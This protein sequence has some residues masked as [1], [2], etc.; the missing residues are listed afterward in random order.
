MYRGAG[1][2]ITAP[3]AW[4]MALSRILRLTYVAGQLALL[5]QLDLLFKLCHIFRAESEG[6]G[7]LLL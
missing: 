6:F 2:D 7:R 1:P 5:V 4:S 3:L